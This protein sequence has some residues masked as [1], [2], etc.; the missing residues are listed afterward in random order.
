MSLIVI[1]KI[2]GL[3]VN[4]LTADKNY[5]LRDIEKLPQLIEMQF[6]KK[7]KPFP[8]FFPAFLQ[9]TSNFEHFEPRSRLPF[10]SQHA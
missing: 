6:S 1:S 3:L 2:L 5:S 8:Q 9:H 4:T 10:D 7:Q